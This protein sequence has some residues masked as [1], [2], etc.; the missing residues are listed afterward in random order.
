MLRLGLTRA[1]ILGLR[2][3]HIDLTPPPAGGINVVADDAS[4]RHRERRL[5][6]DA[7]GVAILREHLAVNEPAD[8]LYPVGFQAINGMVARVARNAGIARRVTPHSLRE[9]FA[10]EQ[11]GAG[12]SESDLIDVL[13]LADDARNRESMARYIDAAGQ[14]ST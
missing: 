13:G 14:A 3:E 6:L 9:T 1:E 5:P 4:N 7:D 10:I 2:L 11:A 8:R 12:A